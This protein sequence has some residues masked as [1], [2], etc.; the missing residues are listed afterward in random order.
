MVERQDGTRPADDADEVA[1]R[2]I[3]TRSFIFGAKTLATALV[4][5]VLSFATDGDTRPAFWTLLA[6]GALGV[7]FGFIERSTTRGVEVVNQRRVNLDVVGTVVLALV[8]NLVV[9]VAQR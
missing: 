9:H 6:V 2:P 3:G 4:A 8:V 7:M 1:D 5:L